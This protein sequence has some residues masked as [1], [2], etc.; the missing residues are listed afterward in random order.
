MEYARESIL[1]SAVR[2]FC[3]AFAGIIGLLIGL[4]LIFLILMTFSSPDIY[5][6]K[7]SL[8]I[9]PDADGDRKLL[10]HAPVL[11]KMDITG[12]IGQGDLTAHKFQNSLLDSREDML[13][14][15][16]VKG[17]LLYINTPG[18]TVDDADA[19]YRALLNYKKKYQV[20]IYAYV[21]G[22][23][24]S[25]G[26]YVASSCDKIF[27]SPSSVIG[28]IGVILG[29]AFNFSGLMDR[30]GIQSLTI[31]E[32]KNKDMLN[33]FR[34][35]RPGEDT[36]F[37]NI[38]A[39]LYERFV[40]VVTAARPNLDRDKLINEYG[41]QIYVSNEAQKLG[42]IDEG[43]A[44]YVLAISELAKEAKI[45]DDQKYQVM[46]ISP[47]RPFLSELAQGKF[48]LLSGKLTH[49]FQINAYMNSELSGRF[50]YMYEP[51]LEL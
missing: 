13:A 2:T 48:S 40:T 22:M 31:T 32:G 50:L 28:S 38:T 37:R 5:P 39:D 19:I 21:D 12:V 46:T 20:P 34:P 47:M 35:W 3:K 10:P 17:V 49:H 14:S 15:G 24:A 33:P 9:S 11:L 16:R 8:L 43:N 30:Y 45:P 1:I 41:A 4:V 44:D 29:P 42:Y 36:S 7:S 27:A 18:G 51:G 23:C 6:P 26:M 25:G